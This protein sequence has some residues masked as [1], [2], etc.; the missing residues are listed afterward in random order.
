MKIQR[1]EIISFG[2]WRDLSIEFDSGLNYIYGTNE[3]GKTTVRKFVQYVLFGLSPSERNLVVPKDTGML[4]GK[5][6]ITNNEERFI[7]ERSSHKDKGKRIVTKN[8]EP[9]PE[10]D[11]QEIFPGINSHTFHS[12]FSFQARDLYQIRNK[13]KEEVGKVLFNLGLT[14]SEEIAN[15]EKRATVEAEKL[16]KKQGKNP[17]INQKLLQLKSISE[18]E[19]RIREKESTYKGL[20]EEETHLEN[21]WNDLVERE[22]IIKSR[23]EDHQSLLQVKH[24]LSKYQLI[25]QEIQSFDD[26]S[27][28][29]DD[30]IDR[31]YFLRDK[32]YSIQEQEQKVHTRL[33]QVEQQVEKLRQQRKL[34]S[35][36]E[37]LQAISQA[38]K[39]WYRDNDERNET[40]RKKESKEAIF[41]QKLQENE[42][43]LEKEELSDLP[44]T[45]YIKQQWETLKFRSET[46][47]ESQN[48]L[49]RKQKS[50]K[51]EI[52]EVEHD[53]N[54]KREKVLP[55]TERGFVE[56]QLYIYNQ[57]HSQDNEVRATENATKSKSISQ[58][59]TIMKWMISSILLA[60]AG[61]WLIASPATGFLYYIIPVLFLLATVFV[62]YML[63]Q[64]TQGLIET[65]NS[66]KQ[67]ANID[68]TELRSR[69]S[70]DNLLREEVNE[71]TVKKDLIEADERELQR[72]IDDQE[73]ELV[74]LDGA[75]DE[76]R[77]KNPLLQ[78]I[79]IEYW[80]STYDILYTAKQLALDIKDLEKTK[81]NLTKSMEE[82]ETLLRQVL[83]ENELT[84][85][86]GENLVAKIEQLVSIE[87]EII[88]QLEKERGWI[89]DITQEQRELQAS[90]QPY[91]D[92]MEDI[93]HTTGA[94]R[95]E[96]F[97]AL[98]HQVEQKANL[99]EERKEHFQLI[100][101][102]YGDQA[103]SIVNQGYYWNKME[104]QVEEDRDQLDL[105]QNRKDDIRQTLANINASIEQMEE[106]GTLSDI[107]HKRSVIE[108]EINDLAKQWAVHQTVRGVLR[109]TKAKYQNEYLPN[110]LDETAVLLNE[111]TNGA[112]EEVKFTDDENLLVKHSNELWFN[113]QQLSEGTA[114][115][116]Y[117]SLRIALNQAVNQKQ[118]FPFLLDDP[119]VHFDVERKSRMMDLLKHKSQSQQIIY[120]SK[121][122]APNN[123]FKM[124]RLNHKNTIE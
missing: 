46:L 111:L 23:L 41:Q 60:S 78:S 83:N 28:V 89:R 108:A 104:R 9:V 122:P 62:F 1:L 2:K 101:Q 37:S 7:I 22:T 121:E 56:H 47:R 110:V 124:I 117:I 102:A 65:P 115:Q 70:S 81:V 88:A 95:E 55:E 72:E 17:L 80:P 31:Y 73:N 74:Q 10:S 85:E 52:T 24:P 64:L 114:D 48:K 86:P 98:L 109:R 43:K 79:P 68:I 58:Y 63:T 67:F 66:D 18:D 40:I 21:E 84:L 69:L 35:A 20:K 61:G 32:I 36:S 123:D 120:F 93:Y 33:Q 16:F 75:I 113:V 49:Q 29:T 38:I 39:T 5:I 112:Y 76:Q 100:F 99:L 118:G 94:A 15:I 3:A 34:I 119:F 57:T 14:G 82:K 25:E 77:M 107:L 87:M 97:V 30:M 106:D 54:I 27:L 12:I 6:H 19:N 44:L 11:F 116:L 96:E 13:S 50:K 51:E 53:L 26:T 103:T 8:G 59:A 105:I 4:A 42:L 45:T 90:K 92:E 71:L 91:L